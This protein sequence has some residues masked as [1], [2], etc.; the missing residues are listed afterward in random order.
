PNYKQNPAAMFVARATAEVCRWIAA[1]AVMGMPYAAEE[2]EDHPQ[3]APSPVTRR[4]TVADLDEPPA[5]EPAEPRTETQKGRMFA[6]W[7]E[8]GYTNSE[9]DRANRLLLTS[10]FID[11]EV[12]SSND[13]TRDEADVV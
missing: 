2:I 6:L 9:Q 11:R 1:D 3:L 5:I 10:G 7:G 4:L 13:L 8:L 12:E